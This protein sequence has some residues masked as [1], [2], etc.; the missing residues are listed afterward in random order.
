MPDGPSCPFTFRRARPDDAAE[1]ATLF[2]RVRRGKLPYLPRPY[3][4]QEDLAFFRDHVM[5]DCTVWVA[6]SESILG[7]VAFRPGWVDQ[8]Y[9]DLGQ[10]GRGIGS[11]LLDKAMATEP[12]LQLWAFRRN[13]AAIAFY[14]HKG[15]KIVA[16]T[17]GSHNEEHEPDT[18]LAWD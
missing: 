1:I 15:F 16:E 9:V 18:L 17:D 13:R 8:L 10:H 3:T 6:G 2:A 5:R 11:A 14:L 7:F 4:P 12:R